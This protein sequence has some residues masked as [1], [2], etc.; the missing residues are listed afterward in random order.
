MSLRDIYNNGFLPVTQSGGIDWNA[1]LQTSA[2]RGFDVLGA[3]YGKGDYISPDDPRYRQ[4]IT[5]SGSPVPTKN[6]DGIE[7]SANAS[8]KGITG[9]LQIDTK[10]LVIGGLVLVVVLV[11]VSSKK[12]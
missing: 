7:L 4:L 10:T 8:P 5:Q 2:Q 12:H 9:G 1:L 3:A 6:Q 11:L